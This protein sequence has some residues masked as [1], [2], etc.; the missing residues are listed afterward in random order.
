MKP[1]SRKGETVSFNALLLIKIIIAV[2]FIIFITIAA[3]KIWEAIFG[4]AD[5]ASIKS[6]DTLYSL[7]ESKAQLKT[8]Y[9]SSLMNMYLKQNYQIYYFDTTDKIACSGTNSVQKYILK[10]E[11]CKTGKSCI[12]LYDSQKIPEEKPKIE[13]R[14]DGVVKCYEFSKEISL[15]AFE[16][17]NEYCKRND[18]AQFANFIIAQQTNPSNGA[19]SIYVWK[20]NELNRKK[21]ADLKAPRCGETSDTICLGQKQNEYINDPSM[22]AVIYGVCANK[23]KQTLSAYCKY[24][25]TTN[26]CIVECRNEI[27]CGKN[28]K[29][30]ADYDKYSDNGLF[31]NKFI[32]TGSIAEW[33][34]NNDICKISQGGC[35]ASFTYNA[36]C[37]E[38]VDTC[39]D[40]FNKWS[41][42]VKDACGLHEEFETD[43][44]LV[45]SYKDAVVQILNPDGTD[46]GQTQSC[47]DIVSQSVFK[48]NIPVYTYKSDQNHDTFPDS[49]EWKSCNLFLAPN[50]IKIVQLYP[51][52]D[53]ACSTTMA[54]YLTQVLNCQEK[55]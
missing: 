8:F 35:S 49:A 7:L 23:A 45:I 34:C 47:T 37:D 24:D 22:Y 19:Q 13:D 41:Q 36:M 52:S 5:K 38:G 12:C 55:I 40:Y 15:K 17:N 10:P 39:D 14:N 43:K 30:C 54:K 42:S 1:Y 9:D 3:I 20:D 21:D 50:G 2:L 44:G 31:T 25:A 11:D 16:I 33:S 26:K 4:N 48:N 51:S 46:S 18:N 6:L 27:G 28:I 29:S 53:P 32:L